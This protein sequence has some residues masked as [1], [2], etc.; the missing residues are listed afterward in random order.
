MSDTTYFVVAVAAIIFKEDRILA[1]KRSLSKD[2]GPGLWETLSGRVE[3]GE[4]PLDAVTREIEEECGLE[5]EVDPRP[6]KAYHAARNNDPMILILYRA[7][8]KSGSVRLSEEHDEYA[9]LTPDEFAGVST[10]DR[11]VDVVYETLD[12]QTMGD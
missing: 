4:D 10:L 9:W 11:L 7:N 3:E 2:A 5:V 8:Y 12:L 1:M 6:V